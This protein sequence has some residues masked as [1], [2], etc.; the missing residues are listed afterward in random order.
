MKQSNDQHKR[1]E[2]TAVRFT[3]SLTPANY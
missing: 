2:T 1:D 3:A